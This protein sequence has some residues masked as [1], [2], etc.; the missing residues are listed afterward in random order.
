MTTLGLESR[1][2]QN[3]ALGAVVLWRFAHKYSEAHA[4]RAATPFCLCALILPMVWH[5]ETAEN[6][7]S[8]R[9]ASGLRAFA[10]K[11]SDTRDS[12]LDTLLALHGRTARW[13]DKTMN[14]MR[15]AMGCGL[16]RFDGAGGL[17]A[18]DIEWQPAK[19]PQ[20]VRVQA[21]VAEKLGAWFAALSLL[22]IAAILRV[23]F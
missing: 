10:D 21:N 9:E 15:V 11:F 4:L 8:T 17:L 23:R 14:S 7:T 20:T 2:V 12:R 18:G 6:I 1:L 22:E 3:P 5:A 13:Q 19:H 16:L